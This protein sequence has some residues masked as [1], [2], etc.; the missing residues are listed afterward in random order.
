MSDTRIVAGYV[1][2]SGKATGTNYTV[3]SSGTGHYSVTFNPPYQTI[4]GGSVTIADGAGN[5]SYS[6]I[7]TSHIA[8]TGASIKICNESGDPATR[9]FSFVFAGFGYAANA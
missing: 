9:D 1:N 3:H 7:F 6:A 5:A 2:S 8:T 4:Y